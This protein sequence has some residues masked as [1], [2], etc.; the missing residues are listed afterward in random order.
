MICDT[1]TG[2]YWLHKDTVHLSYA[3]PIQ[4]T[5]VFV[6]EDSAGQLHRLPPLSNDT[7]VGPER[8]LYRKNRL[9]RIDSTGHLVKKEMNGRG[10]RRK[11][12][13]IRDCKNE[14][15]YGFIFKQEDE[16]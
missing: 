13:L 9:Y 1:A 14:D 4:D 5:T 15:A 6:F 12:Y 16:I 8:F 2:K 11:W 10:K 7:V 3:P